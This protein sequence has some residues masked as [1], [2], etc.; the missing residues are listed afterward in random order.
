VASP[1]MRRI[2]RLNLVLGGILVIVAAITQPRDI[3][4]GV[5]VGVALTCVNFFVLARLIARWTADAAKGVAGPASYL[6][7]PKMIGLMIAI[8]AALKYLPIDPAG[9][10]LGF[11]VFVISIVIETIYSN[12]IPAEPPPA[13]PN[14]GT[15]G[16]STDG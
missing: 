6:M 5:A 3:A 2:T 15:N 8:V 10:A 13:D 12:M 1:N 14:S 9:F 7:M 16:A 4:L 11:S